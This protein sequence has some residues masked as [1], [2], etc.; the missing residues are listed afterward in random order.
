MDDFAIIQNCTW[1]FEFQCPRQWAQLVTTDDPL[2]RTCG[3]CLKDVYLCR[4]P[5]EVP[6]HARLGHCVAIVPDEPNA[7]E[8]MG[9]VVEVD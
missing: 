3:A 9:E 5:D 7:S 4:T 1:K 8:L 2:V 6:D